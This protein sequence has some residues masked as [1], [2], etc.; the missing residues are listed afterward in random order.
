MFSGAHASFVRLHVRT[1]TLIG[2]GCDDVLL[3]LFVA[4]FSR[5]TYNLR[6]TIVTSYDLRVVN[7]FYS[8]SSQA[9]YWGKMEPLTVSSAIKAV[10]ASSR[11]RLLNSRG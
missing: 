11:H 9:G 1:E 4:S 10:F 6:L 3:H 8:F 7:I 5:N 2:A